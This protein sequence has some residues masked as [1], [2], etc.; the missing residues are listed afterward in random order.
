MYCNT[1]CYSTTCR[2]RSSV[3][4]ANAAQQFSSA[5]SNGIVAIDAVTPACL[6]TAC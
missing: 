4:V 2:S 1:Y 5:D 6:L 3:A